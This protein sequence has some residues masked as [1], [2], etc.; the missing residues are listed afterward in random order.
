MTEFHVYHLQRQTLEAALPTLLMRAGE[1]GWRALVKVGTPDR[2][3][4][5]DDHLWTFNDESFLAHGTDGETDPSGQPVLLTLG[6]RNANEARMLFL[7][8]GAALPE[9]LDGYE[10]VAL[11]LD[12]RDEAA[13]T[14][15][16]DVWRQVREAGHTVAYWQ[17]GDDGR[18]QKRA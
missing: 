6:D 14:S 15:A 3:A 17:Q 2:M 11:L 4:A 1:R 12:G 9:T 18:W 5:L 13:V 10:R 8:D 7:V 16:R